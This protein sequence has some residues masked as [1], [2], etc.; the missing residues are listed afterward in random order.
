MGW[1][2]GGGGGGG[3][4][5]YSLAATCL[6]YCTKPAIAAMHGP[7]NLIRF[8]DWVRNKLNY[9]IGPLRSDSVIK[10][11]SVL[12]VNVLPWSLRNADQWKPDYRVVTNEKPRNQERFSTDQ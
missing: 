12:S 6:G 2:G 10:L 8:C 4:H 3:S 11:V 7:H 9:R 5:Q 1:G